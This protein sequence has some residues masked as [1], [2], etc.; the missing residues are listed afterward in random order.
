MGSLL[1]GA[2]FG[3]GLTLSGVASPQVIKGQFQLSDFHMLATFLTASASSA[4]IFAVYNLRGSGKKITTKQPSSHGWVGSYDGNIIGGA[5]IGLGM[6]LTGACPGTVLVQAVSGI[7]NSRLLAASVLFAGIVWAKLKPYIIGKPTKNQP[8]NVTV[9]EATGW[10]ARRTI[11]SYEMAL[12]SAIGAT[13][14]LAPRS[15]GLLHPV[16]GGVLIGLGQLSSVILTE[17][18]VGVSTAYEEGGKLFWDVV[19]RR[20][21]KLSSLSDSIMFACGILA[22]SWLTM[23]NVPAAREALARSGDQSLLSIMIGG[24][25]LVFGA[26]TAGGCTSGH[27]ISGMA[28]MGLSSFV[29]VACMFGTGLIS[30]SMCL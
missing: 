5:M 30:G 9:M 26:R 14:G 21:V 25:L 22:G 11:L 23:L 19:E 17:K 18:P 7:G 27:G 16:A 1:S 20:K 29:T 2:I 28:S 3:T 15:Q 24:F 13:L 10:S 6:S 12:F 4:A 8:G